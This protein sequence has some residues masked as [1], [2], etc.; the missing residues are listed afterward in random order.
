MLLTHKQTNKQTKTGKSIIS[1]AE[2]T[3]VTFMS[4][5]SK[6]FLERAS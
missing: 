3:N 1:L 2:V 4:N 5:S 6:C